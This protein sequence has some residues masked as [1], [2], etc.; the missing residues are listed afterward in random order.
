MTCFYSTYTRVTCWN[1]HN[2]AVLSSNKKNNVLFQNR[3]V[4][5]CFASIRLI[6]KLGA[7]GIGLVDSRGVDWP[8]NYEHFIFKKGGD[9]K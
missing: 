5:A 8:R 9:A 3:R 7:R 4:E 1:C 2:D 6:K